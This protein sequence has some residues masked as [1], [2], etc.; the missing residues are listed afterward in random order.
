MRPFLDDERLIMLL[1]NQH[2]NITHPKVLTLPLGNPS[3]LT[4]IHLW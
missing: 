3:L 1:V 4:Y 2:H